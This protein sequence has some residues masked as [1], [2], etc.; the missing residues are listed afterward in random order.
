M[1]RDDIRE[2]SHAITAENTEKHTGN[3][4]TWDD[5][6]KGRHLRHNQIIGRI[7]TH[8]IKRVYLL[9]Y[10]HR[11]NLRGDTRSNLSRQ[12]QT[13]DGRGELQKQGVT[14]R[15]TRSIVR[16]KR[17]G[18]IQ[19]HLDGNHGS[20]KHGNNHRNSQRIKALLLNFIYILSEKHT[21]PVRDGKCPH[22]QH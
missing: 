19:N 9:R 13:E 17:I 14:N 12:Y 11:S 16:Q 6:H 10:P 5:R 18:R 7:D 4:Q 1:N 21:P 3:H 15:Q 8:N 20:D 2:I 22:H